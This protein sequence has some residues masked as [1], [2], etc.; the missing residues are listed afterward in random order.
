MVI[1]GE[2]VMV[3]WSRISELKSEIGE[4][5]FAEVVEIFLDEM[6]EVIVRLKTAPDPATYE[7][8]LHFLKG[9][10]WNLGFTRFGAACGDGE[11]NA[12]GGKA[13][14]VNIGSLIDCY[15]QSKAEFLEGLGEGRSGDVS[16]AA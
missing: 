6:E 15:E 8:D 13:A 3:D 12:A 1:V 5:G 11:K 14:D 9:G 10:A 7:V 2:V 4:D 16:S